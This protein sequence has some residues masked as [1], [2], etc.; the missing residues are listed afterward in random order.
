MADAW[1]NLERM[2]GISEARRGTRLKRG[3]RAGRQAIIMARFTSRAT[4]GWGK[5]LVCYRWSKVCC[6]R[7]KSLS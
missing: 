7:E 6:G 4:V 5:V 3:V 1:L 2:D